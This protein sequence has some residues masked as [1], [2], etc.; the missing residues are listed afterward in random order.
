MIPV[1]ATCQN[2]R[3]WQRHPE[4]E[5]ERGFCLANPPTVEGL[6]T[7]EIRMLRPVTG[8]T[9]PACRKWGWPLDMRFND[10]RPKGDT[11]EAED[12]PGQPEAARDAEGGA[13][14]ERPAPKLAVV[15]DEDS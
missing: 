5:N 6:G 4:P 1:N 12:S 10:A 7:K 14:G 3:W 2:C 15:A 9:E 13:D 11:D 8:A